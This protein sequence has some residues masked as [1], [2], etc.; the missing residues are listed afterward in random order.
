MAVP[1][2]DTQVVDNKMY[3]PPQNE[4]AQLTLDEVIERLKEKEITLIMTEDAKD[5]I[6]EKGTD[7]EYGARPLR[8]AVQQFVEDPLSEQLL[9]GAY[10]P[11]T[12]IVVRYTEEADG[13]LFDTEM[14]VAESVST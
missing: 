2:D 3:R 14:P 8:R 11:G 13:L 6:V 10:E 9:M 5:Y 7:D 1:N 4:E 12:Q